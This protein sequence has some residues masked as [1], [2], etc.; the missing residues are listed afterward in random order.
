MECLFLL[1]VMTDEF[2][3]FFF[4]ISNCGKEKKIWKENVMSRRLMTC[5]N[6]E[7]CED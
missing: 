1:L 4:L 3:N 2:E 7:V 6:G 5:C